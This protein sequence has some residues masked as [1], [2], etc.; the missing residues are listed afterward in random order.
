MSAKEQ[1]SEAAESTLVT[2]YMWGSR[3]QHQAGKKKLKLLT[4]LAASEPMLM[5]Q[6][7]TGTWAARYAESGGTC[8]Q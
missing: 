4:T 3:Y 7:L 1:N 2:K 5:A 6:C 8:L